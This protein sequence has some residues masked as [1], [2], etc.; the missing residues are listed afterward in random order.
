MELIKNPSDGSGN[1]VKP[2]KGGMRDKIAGRIR[3]GVLV[4]VLLVIYQIDNSAYL[5]HLSKWPR[6]A[7]LLL[8]ALVLVQIISYMAIKVWIKCSRGDG[9]GEK[10]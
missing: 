7:V 5:D 10:L 4:V 8:A 6:R 9:S 2:D 1:S 3:L